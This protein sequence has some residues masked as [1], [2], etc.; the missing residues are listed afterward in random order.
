MPKRSK[1]K[2]Q[3]GNS[4][5]QADVIDAAYKAQLKLAHAEWCDENREAIAEHNAR[6]EKNGPLLSPVWA[7]K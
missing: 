1:I 7:D 3:S 2:A 6:L 5:M 4:T